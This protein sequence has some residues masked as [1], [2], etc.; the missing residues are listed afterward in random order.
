MPSSHMGGVESWMPILQQSAGHSTW[1]GLHVQL[2]SACVM[3][4]TRWREQE[5]MRISRNHRVSYGRM[6]FEPAAR[7]YL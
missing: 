6:D 1:Q 3:E 5:A 2:A 4:R 7:R